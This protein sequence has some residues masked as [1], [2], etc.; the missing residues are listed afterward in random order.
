V[1]LQ[2]CKIFHTTSGSHFGKSCVYFKSCILHIIPTWTFSIFYD[3]SDETCVGQFSKSY[4]FTFKSRKVKL[5]SSEKERD[6]IGV[7][8][9]SSQSKFLKLIRS[10]V[11]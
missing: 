10:L 4:L 11:Y 5:L 6:P 8:F 7:Q 3:V 2:Y 1:S 9:V